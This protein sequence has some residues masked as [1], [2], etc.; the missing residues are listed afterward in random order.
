[1]APQKTV[2]QPKVKPSAPREQERVRKDEGGSITAMIRLLCLFALIGLLYGQR[3]GDKAVPQA[4]L[5]G[6]KGASQN[7]AETSPVVKEAKKTTFEPSEVKKN[8]INL[9]KSQGS[10]DIAVKRDEEKIARK[11]KKGKGKGKGGFFFG[12]PGFVGGVGPR[13]NFSFARRP[14]VS[15]FGPGPGFG[16]G[17]RGIPGR[18]FVG[19]PFA[20]RPFGPGGFYGG[21]FLGGGFYGS[22]F[23]GGTAVY[24]DYK[25]K[26]KPAPV[27]YVPVEVPVGVGV[28]GAA[29]AAAATRSSTT[30]TTTT[31]SAASSANRVAGEVVVDPIVGGVI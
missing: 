3:V 6:S 19:R 1:M 31:S 13:G 2:V 28:A 15:P 21:G 10:E 7:A 18:P 8:E 17:P 4:Q 25:G 29:T 27:I 24:Y 22:A 23:I 14:F 5:R 9:M 12:G 26:P 20:V 11:L 16:L 30:T